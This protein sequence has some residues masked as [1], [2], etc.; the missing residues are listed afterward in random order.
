MGRLHVVSIV[1]VLKPHCIFQRG[2]GPIVTAAIHNGHQTRRSVEQRLAIDER[3]QLREEDPLTGEWTQIA[4]T[5]IVG[6]RSRFEIDLNR[7]RDQAVYKTPADAWGLKVWELP[8]DR[9]MI[10]ASLREYDLFYADV[11]RLLDEMLEDYPRLV[12][13]DLHTY[14]Q[15][16]QGPDGPTADPLLNPEVNVGTGTMNRKFWSPVVDQFIGELR[17]YD[18]HGRSLDVRENVKFRGGNF[19]RWVHDNFP[20]QVCSIAIEFKKFFMDEWAGAPY[21]DEVECIFK[22]LQS[23]LPG[24]ESALEAM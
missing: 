4:N 2:K 6:L 10:E 19:S 20:L 3:Q 24:V 18:F 1:M 17:A 5:Q 16:R 14:N 21:P 15:R 8:P 23:T 7:P 9:D 11:K 13:Y 22:A 12:I